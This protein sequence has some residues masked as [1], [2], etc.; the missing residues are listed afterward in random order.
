M[1]CGLALGSVAGQDIER[2]QDL[3]DL[4]L[5]QLLKVKVTSA[6]LHEQNVKDAPAS[7]T[8]ITSEEIEK[9]GYRTLAEALAYVPGIFMSSDHTNS[10]IGVRGFALPGDYASRA[11]VMINGH[12]IADNIFDE[13][14]WTESDF[15]LDMNLVDRIEVV[16][17]ASSALYGSNGMLATI[18]V[19]TKRP[20]DMSKASVE[21][22]TGSLGER[23]ISTATSVNLGKGAKLIF[24]ASAF[25]DIG[26]RELNIADLSTPMSAI[27]MDG[28]K[29]YHAFADL[30]WGHWEILALTGDRVK[31]QPVSWAPTIFNDRG[32]RVEDSRGFLEISY[33]REFSSDRTLTWKTSYDE[34]RFRGI[35]RFSSDDG[36]IDN[37]E[38]DYGDW[39]GSKLSYRV[40]D[41]FGGHITFGTEARIDLRALQNVFDVH[42]D[43]TQILQVDQ[44]DRF[45]GVFAQQ[46]WSM[47]RHWELNLGLR[48]DWSQLKPNDV[49]GRAAAIYK[50]TSTTDVKFL[51]GR[52]FRNPSNF[53]MFFA[54]GFGQIANPYL[55]PETTD[56]YEVDVDHE[57]TKRLRAGASVYRYRID[58]LIQQTYDPDAMQQYRNVNQVRASGV[59][60][61]LDALLA[62]SLRIESSLDLQRTSLAGGGTLANS[63]RQVG[64]FRLSLPFWRNRLNFGAGVQALGDRQSYDGDH[65][66]WMVVPEI[67]VSTKPLPS[68]LQITGGIKNLSNSYYE[69]AVGL[70]NGV[71]RMP[72]TGRTYYVTLG[73]NS[74][75]PREDSKSPS[76]TEK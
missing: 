26:E 24:S 54:N 19:I 30:T 55:M 14:V 6:S 38:R 15:P 10:H 27:D 2:K 20:E 35:Y 63:P 25:N 72:G 43:T 41:F 73:W 11:I 9:F 22:E 62:H 12:N 64:K 45:I 37:R 1:L 16:R 52:G 49:S 39:L 59:S 48:Y 51:Y 50:P 7:V 4:S 44:P 61:Q 76:R 42:P 68:G 3:N 46:E 56:T 65:L 74:P 32:T 60:L 29:G 70:A 67:V 18:N 75:Q 66:S 47:G 8:V 28:D 21:I 5:E 33:T 23:K 71:D 31:T 13:S 40:P 53:E 17:G 69:Y 57:F 34:Y 36:V 58:D